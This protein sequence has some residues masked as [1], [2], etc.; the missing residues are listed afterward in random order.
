MAPEYGPQG[1]PSKGGK[2]KATVMNT[3]A[4]QSDDTCTLYNIY[5]KDRELFHKGQEYYA[6]LYLKMCLGRYRKHLLSKS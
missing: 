2:I 4:S 3:Q 1:D 6:T 5:T